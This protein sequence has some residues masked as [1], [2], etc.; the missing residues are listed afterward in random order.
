MNDHTHLV[1]A[2][3]V[4]MIM[5]FTLHCVLGGTTANSSLFQYIVADFCRDGLLAVRCAFNSLQGM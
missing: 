1:V 2:V 5:T 4:S 3:T